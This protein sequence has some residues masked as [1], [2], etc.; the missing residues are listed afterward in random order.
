MLEINKI[1]K[2][3]RCCSAQLTIQRYWALDFLDSFVFVFLHRLFEGIWFLQ[4]ELGTSRKHQRIKQKYFLCDLS[5]GIYSGLL[6]KG[7]VRS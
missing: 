6:L 5:N 7:L 3:A 4:T 2:E 1:S